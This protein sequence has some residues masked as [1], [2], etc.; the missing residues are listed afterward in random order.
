MFDKKKR[1]AAKFHCDVVLQN[2]QTAMEHA[3]QKKR[4]ESTMA[5]MSKIED[6]LVTELKGTL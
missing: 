4:H 2:T 1:D 3:K 6:M 5:R